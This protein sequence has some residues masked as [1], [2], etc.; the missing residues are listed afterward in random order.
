MKQGFWVISLLL[1]LGFRASAQ[2]E[3]CTAVAGEIVDYCFQHP[4]LAGYCASFSSNS[5]FLHFENKARKKQLSLRILLPETGAPPSIA[6][7]TGLATDKKLKL[8]ATELLFLEHA[9]LAW[10]VTDG[11]NR[12]DPAVVSSGFTILPSGLAYKILQAG[13]G[14]PP[15]S[16]KTVSVH[17]TGY[18]PD[19]K[20][21]DSS[22]DRKQSFRFALGKGQVIRGWDEG[23]AL[24]QIGSRYLFRI[25]PELAYGSRG[26]GNI[27]PNATLFF[28]V[29]LLA[30][31]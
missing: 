2:C 3:G 22:L 18:F 4:S 20:K 10:Q 9:I 14:N 31:N 21:F 1:L 6:Y 24:M 16:G 30:V 27:P 15:T 5:P 23:V 28:D 12:W 19:G 11:V 29:Q 7:L 17:Y 25:P 13:S 26:M 8:S